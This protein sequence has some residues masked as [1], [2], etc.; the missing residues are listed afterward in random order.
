MKKKFF[1][2]FFKFKFVA[3][4][5]IG[6]SVG[7]ITIWPGIIFGNNRKC[8]MSILRDGSDGNIQVR[9]ILAISPNYLIK[10]KNAKNNY[11]KILLIGDSCFRKYG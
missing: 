1:K 10:I 9:T 8:F 4:F 5:V 3:I 7:V 2:K 11:I 6:F